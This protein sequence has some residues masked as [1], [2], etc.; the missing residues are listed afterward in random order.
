[1]VLVCGL[2]ALIV[3]RARAVAEA[4]IRGSGNG[5]V[6]ALRDAIAR[7]WLAIGMAYVV[8]VF[9]FFIFGLSLG[10]LSYFHAAISTLGVLLVLL[11]L[12]K[13]AARWQPHGRGAVRRSRVERSGGADFP[14]PAARDRSGDRRA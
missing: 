6:A 8:G 4:L 9:V 14:P 3:F 10:L 1:M 5:V 11:V 13:L 7:A 12:E 2:Y